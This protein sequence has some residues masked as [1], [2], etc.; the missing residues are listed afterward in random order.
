MVS[1]PKKAGG[2][3]KDLYAG[4]KVGFLTVIQKVRTPPNSAGGQKS[5]VQCICGTRM[6]IP[7]F[8]LMRRQPKTHCGCKDVV[9]DHPYTKRSWYMMHVRCEDKNHVAYK[10]YG[11]RGITVCERWHKTNPDGWKNFLEDMGPRPEPLKDGTTFSLD[12]FPN[13][14]GNYEPTNCR[15]ATMKQQRA[16]QRER[17][18]K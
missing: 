13:N 3:A 6:T 15:W 16:N 1:V 17:T 8:Y 4:Y 9:A 18:Y 14:D 11:G 10:E 2:Q 12:R 7:R 5:R